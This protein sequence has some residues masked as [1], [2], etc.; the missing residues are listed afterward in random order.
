MTVKTGATI[1]AS[2]TNAIVCATDT[3]VTRAGTIDDDYN[4]VG[5]DGIKVFAGQVA[6]EGNVYIIYKV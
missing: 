3:A 6:D 4:I 2:V 5:A 1:P